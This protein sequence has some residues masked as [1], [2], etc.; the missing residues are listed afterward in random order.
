VVPGITDDARLPYAI[1]GALWGLL[2]VAMTVHGELRLR[3]VRRALD[4]GAFHHP[5]GRATAAFTGA[6]AALGLATVALV[7]VAP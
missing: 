3:A 6:A 7:V 2:A 4:E 1:L 5:S